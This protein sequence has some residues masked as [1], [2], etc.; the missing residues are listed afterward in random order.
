MRAG[1][2]VRDAGIADVAPSLLYLMGLPVPD[3]MDGRV[4]L[5]MV[6]GRFRTAHPVQHTQVVSPPQ[7]GQDRGFSDEESRQVEER[8]RGLGYLE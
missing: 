1:H 7:V 5:D 3:D 4:L 2:Q 8:L 6:E